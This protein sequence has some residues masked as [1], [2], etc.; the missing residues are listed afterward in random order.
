[1][2]S[3]SS[4][5][6]EPVWQ[7]VF[8]PILA[9]LSFVF[10]ALAVFRVWLYHIGVLPSESS[11]SFVVSIG[12]IQAG[13]TGKTP[14]TAFFA[15]RWRQRLRIGIVSRGYGRKTKGSLRVIPQVAD[16]AS[17]YGDEPTWLAQTLKDVPVQVGER[18]VSAAQDLISTEGVKLILLDDG[19]QHLALRRSF[20]FVLVDASAASWHWRLLPW[21]RL[22]EPARGLSRADAILITKTEG[23]SEPNL[24]ELERQLRRW[25]GPKIPLVRFCQHLSFEARPEEVLLVAAGLAN[26]NAFFSMVEADGSKP[27]IADRIAFKDHHVYIQADASRLAARAVQLGASRVLITEK[28]AVKLQPLWRDDFKVELAIARLEVRPA[29]ESDGVQLER[30]DEIILGQV[31]GKVG[32]R[33]QL[34]HRDLTH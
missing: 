3:K 30:I 17:L 2:K 32:A 6:A 19:F 33:N 29:R 23:V 11:G 4:Q 18:R 28:D 8:A 34:P 10:G 26:P 12:N 15:S 20:D 16:A 14:V 1:M 22:R 24:S 5:S 27:R 9:V 25:A 7:K 13:G 21:G 31:R